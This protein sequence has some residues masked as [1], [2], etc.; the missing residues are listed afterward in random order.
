[1]SNPCSASKR[2]KL[3]IDTDEK[4]T[5]VSQGRGRPKTTNDPPSTF[6]KKELPDDPE[7]MIFCTKCNTVFGNIKDL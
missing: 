4:K 2:V 3:E 7:N 6:V 5:D 1:M